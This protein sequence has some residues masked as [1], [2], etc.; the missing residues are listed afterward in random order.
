M[1]SWQARTA[2]KLPL[3]RH[4]QSV[5]LLRTTR[6]WTLW[7][8]P[9]QGTDTC[10]SL[11]MIAGNICCAAPRRTHKLGLQTATL[12]LA[13]RQTR[14]SRAAEAATAAV[15]GAAS[16]LPSKT[17]RVTCVSESRLGRPLGR[18]EPEGQLCG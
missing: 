7:G 4:V 5:E 3:A 14:Q 10:P 12:L 9:G 15:T 6:E 1:C 17:R 8:A 11:H 16:G 2:H 13:H 18:L